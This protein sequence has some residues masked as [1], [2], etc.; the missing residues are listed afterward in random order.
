[1]STVF[2]DVQTALDARLASLSGGLDI[3]FP[4]IPYEPAANETYLRASFLPA[5]VVQAAL[6]ASGKDRIE[7]IYQVDVFTVAGT[8]R[9]NIPDTIADHFK[10]GTNLTYNNN[11]V[12]IINVSINPVI[13]SGSWQQVPVQIDFYSYMTA[14]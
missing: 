8:G 13:I 2:N 9:T 4:N 12:R 11:T 7:G 10:R 6:G 14:R 1:M 3:A 5:E